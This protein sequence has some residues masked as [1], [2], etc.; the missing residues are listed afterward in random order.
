[1]L[2]SILSLF[3]AP[4]LVSVPFYIIYFMKFENIYIYANKI[5]IL[6]NVI[7]LDY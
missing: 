6:T 5:D 4:P 2:A 1:M 7:D 3:S